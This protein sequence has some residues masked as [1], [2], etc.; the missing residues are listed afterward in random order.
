MIA[1]VGAL[2]LEELLPSATAAG[3]ALL[4]VRAWETT[5]AEVD[6]RVGGVVRVVMRDPHKDVEYGGGGR[7]T[8]ID[9]PKAQSRY[10]DVAESMH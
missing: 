1:H 4:V 6:L 3:T 7:Y 2:P 5:V 8:E 9:P 10:L